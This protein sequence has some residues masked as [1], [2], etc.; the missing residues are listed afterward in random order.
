MQAE[1]DIDPHDVILYMYIYIYIYT[2]T[3][4]HIRKLFLP[5]NSHVDRLNMLRWGIVNIGILYNIYK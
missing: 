5:D 4:I 1:K 3:Y 2:H